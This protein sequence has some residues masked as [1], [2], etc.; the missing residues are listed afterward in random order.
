FRVPEEGVSDERRVSLGFGLLLLE[1]VRQRRDAAS[2]RVLA[3]ALQEG[4]PLFED[5]QGAP[6]G[7]LD[8]LS[9]RLAQAFRVVGVADPAA[10]QGDVPFQ[11]LP[12]DTVALRAAE[13]GGFPRL[14]LRVH[15]DRI[16]IGDS[17]FL[18][19]ALG[20]WPR[21]LLADRLPGQT[22]DQGRDRR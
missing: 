2:G 12:E 22:I 20:Y 1:V 8:R 15:D 16:K 21:L 19:H 9:L 5:P 10:V 14:F 6:E 4:G 13:G 18:V 17:Q 11:D 3:Q 7:P